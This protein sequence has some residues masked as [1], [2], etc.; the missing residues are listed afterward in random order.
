MCYDDDDVFVIATEPLEVH[1]E[2][3]ADVD[4]GDESTI[5]P[6]H[7]GYHQQSANVHF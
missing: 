7:L 6:S 2:E 5:D 3:E 4:S 1:K